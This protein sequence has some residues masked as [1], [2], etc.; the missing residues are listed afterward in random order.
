MYTTAFL[1][2]GLGNQMFQISNAYAQALKNNKE[3]FFRPYS[4]TP[5]QG[6]QTTTYVDNI[7]RNLIFKN[8]LTGFV[9]YNEPD[10]TYN[11]KNFNIETPIEFYGYY[12]SSKNFLGYI[13][14]IKKLFLID[15]ENKKYLLEK[16]PELKKE[17]TL[18]IHIRRGDYKKHP[19]VH[20]TV[21]KSYIQKSLDKIGGYSHIFILSDDKNWAIENLSLPNS[22]IV[23][24]KD[25]LELW[26]MSLCQNNILSNSSFSW[27]GSFL[28]ENKNKKTIAPSIWF[29]PNGPRNFKDIFQ[30]EWDILNVTFTNGE[31][32]IN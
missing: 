15:E 6:N 24:E 2:G 4:D 14:E 13:N 25:Y 9:R 22:T 16:Y 21:S 29:G 20:P 32:I 3:C 30:D 10:W 11:E 31:L 8:D 7:F 18:S 23:D 27:W 26:L 1:M 19:L 28:N 17:N 5:N 12:Q